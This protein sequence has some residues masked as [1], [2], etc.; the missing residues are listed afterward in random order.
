M[1]NLKTE[2]E[3][4]N[5]EQ[6][7]EIYDLALIAQFD[8]FRRKFVKLKNSAPQLLHLEGGSMSQRASF[9]SYYAALHICQNNKT[10]QE[11]LGN[12]VNSKELNAKKELDYILQVPCLNCV[13][14]V[15]IA[16]N[17]HSDVLVYDGRVE[18]IKVEPMRD[19]KIA[20]GDPP[21]K[22]S[23]RVVILLEADRLTT[24]A[25]NTLLKV[26][27]EPL[28]HTLF[29]FTTAQRQNLLPTLISRGF[30]LTLPWVFHSEKS[31]AEKE[32]EEEISRFLQ[33]GNGLF[34]KLSPKGVMTN[35]LAKELIIIVQRNLADA[36]AGR[37]TGCT[38]CK[39]LQ[40]IS[41]V[42]ADLVLSKAEEA[43]QYLTN[44]VYVL[45]A[46]FSSLYNLMP[47]K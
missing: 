1:A 5:P 7:L 3:D 10:F 18:S 6:A 43:L 39:T 40:L 23:K 17:F 19:L 21:R 14:C 11:S 42:Q 12:V 34:D 2:N 47:K 28:K 22:G 31:L 13:N 29:I 25:A 41:F 37:E 9:A 38:L 36:I 16:A 26:L 35:N 24:E 46:M 44:P 45:E 15:K 30:V 4:L 20:V 33:S 32:W 8:N 27:E